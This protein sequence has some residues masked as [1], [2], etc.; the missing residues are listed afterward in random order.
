MIFNFTV[1]GENDVM[2]NASPKGIMR[3]CGCTI[4]TTKIMQS[5][6]FFRKG[7]IVSMPPVNDERLIVGQYMGY[8]ARDTITL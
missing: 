2:L 4:N 7:D 8:L 5:K 3:C 1:A 6:A